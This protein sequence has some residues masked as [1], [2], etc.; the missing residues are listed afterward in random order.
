MRILARGLWVVGSLLLL[1]LTFFSQ[2]ISPAAGAQLF[3]Y[4]EIEWPPGRSK[5]SPVRDKELA[6]DASR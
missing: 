2:Q 5:A 3:A 4:G 6:R 1:G